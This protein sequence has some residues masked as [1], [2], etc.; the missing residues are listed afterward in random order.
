MKFHLAAIAL[1][2]TCAAGASLA[3]QTVTADMLIASAQE[4]LAARS[5]GLP[6]E[7]EY[8]PSAGLSA[9]Q[10]DGAGPVRVEAGAVG[11]T[12]PRRRVGVPV[13]I[14]IEDQLEQSRIVWFTVR[15][16]QDVPVYVRDARAGDRADGLS[17]RTMRTDLAGVDA[18]HAVA[19]SELTSDLRLR[20]TVRAGQ[21]VLDVD[22]EPVPAV[23][24]Q[25]SIALTVRE[26]A[27]AVRTAAIAQRDAEVGERIKVLPQGAD[28]WIQARVVARNEVAVDD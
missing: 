2:L 28:Q 7:I 19:P 5:A 20:R 9:S 4:A 6:G 26:G 3:A 1:S 27:I 25:Q 17:V 14:W 21:P 23:A 13:H 24:R 10:V 11:G 18:Q 8:V 16:W 12:W 22:F 15:W